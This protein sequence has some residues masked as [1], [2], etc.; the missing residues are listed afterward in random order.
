MTPRLRTK[1]TLVNHQPL[2]P[3]ETMKHVQSITLLLM[4]AGEQPTAAF[5]PWLARVPSVKD[6]QFFMRWPH[7]LREFD[8]QCMLAQHFFLCTRPATYSRALVPRSM[9][10]LAVLN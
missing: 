6:V 4:D 7:P 1:A 3:P 2:P 9:G 5:F 8:H 10:Q